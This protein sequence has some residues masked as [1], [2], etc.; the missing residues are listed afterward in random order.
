MAQSR[1]EQLTGSPIT[2][3][4]FFDNNWYIVQFNASNNHKEL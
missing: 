3:D 1:D 4:I 2:R